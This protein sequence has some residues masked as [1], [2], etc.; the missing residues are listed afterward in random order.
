MV[1]L[2]AIT[3][4]TILTQSPQSPE[5]STNK[6][7]IPEIISS[8]TTMDCQWEEGAPLWTHYWGQD[9]APTIGL[10][11][12]DDLQIRIGINLLEIKFHYVNWLDFTQDITCNHR[13]KNYATKIAKTL[14]GNEII[15]LPDSSFLECEARSFVGAGTMEELKAWL[16]N[17]V[18]PPAKNPASIIQ[19]QRKTSSDGSII[20]E[21]SSRG[22]CF[23]SWSASDERSGQAG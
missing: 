10:L 7:D 2:V 21:V 1:T 8:A 23:H 14:G 4:Q 19:R 5:F 22:Y 11:C 12:G 6:K 17:C 15:F 9:A 3:P 13:I 20:Y 18:G 16:K